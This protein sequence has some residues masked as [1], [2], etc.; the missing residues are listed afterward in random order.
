MEP[1]ETTTKSSASSRKSWRS[2][3]GTGRGRLTLAC[4]GV[5][6][7]AGHQPQV[8]RAA[9]IRVPSAESTIQR[10]VDIAADGDTVLVAGG[11]YDGLETR[12]IYRPQSTAPITANVFIDKPIFLMSETGAE[13][14]T[15]QGSGLGPVI[16]C[17][18]A[19]GA[20][21][22][23]FT[24]R[25]GDVDETVLD[26]GGGIYCEW[27][28]LEIRDNIIED[29][30]G[31]FGGGICLL[32]G[33]TCEIGNNII[34]NNTG[35]AS[36]G[37]VAVLDGSTS[38]IEMN[39]IAKNEAAVYGGALF[40]ASPSPIVVR[41]NTIVGNAAV[42][43]SAMFC[44]S[45]GQVTF[46]ANIVAFGSGGDAV[47]CDTLGTGLHCL[48]TSSCND[49]WASEG[50]SQVGC[51]PG[52]GDREVDPLFCSYDT[53]DYA[54]CVFS[55]SLGINDD[56]GWRGALP[57][58]CWSCPAQERRLTWGVLKSLYR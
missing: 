51:G 23:G 5:C 45:G 50:E 9:V 24:I 8:V 33:T 30:S 4:L 31:P 14:T 11:V 19:Q 39:V 17:S 43:G 18:L 48:I 27:S 44:R 34:R 52:P 56:C 26:G 32:T 55:P 37:A 2:A 21:I 47:F 41:R 6:L 54:L 38:I 28:N 3:L 25:G 22:Q 49:F 16:V 42:A 20:T 57:A 15:I 29:N 36:G 7:L 46:T 53:G 40:L 12:S 1:W 13:A 10:A 58:G 35:D